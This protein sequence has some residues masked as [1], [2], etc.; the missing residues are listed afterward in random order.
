MFYADVK[1]LTGT[2]RSFLDQD[3]SA[4]TNLQVGADLYMAKV[5]IIRGGFTGRSFTTGL[6]LRFGPLH[7]DVAA[8]FGAPRTGS[9]SDAGLSARA[10]LVF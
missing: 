7:L 6:G 8:L 9:V 5:F 4:W 10:A 2:W 1:D 3:E